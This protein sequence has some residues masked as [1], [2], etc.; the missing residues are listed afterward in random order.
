MAPFLDTVFIGGGEPSLRINAIKE[1][2]HC[3]PVYYAR[4]KLI[5]VSNGSMS[6]DSLYTIIDYADVYISRH[7]IKDED[8]IS[9]LNPNNNTHILSLEDLR[10]FPAT[11][12]ITFCPVCVKDGLDSSEKIIEYI[13][14][15]NVK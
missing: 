4:P 5:V 13:S 9:I 2:Y 15:S 10:N 7:A 11:N 14:K 1:I 6:I 3:F 12:K 8:N